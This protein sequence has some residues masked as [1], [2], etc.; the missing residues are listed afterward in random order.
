MYIKAL[1]LALNNEPRWLISGHFWPLL[2]LGQLRK[3]TLAK[4]ETPNQVKLC[5]NPR[6]LLRAGCNFV[7][8]CDF[9]VLQLIYFA[10]NIH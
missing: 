1:D 10:V 6:Y 3:M 2:K 8:E 9:Y 4:N 5:N 7:F